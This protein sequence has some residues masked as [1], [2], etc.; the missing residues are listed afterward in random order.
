MM[1]IKYEV[2]LNPVDLPIT[3]VSLFVNIGVKHDSICGI[4]HLIE[5]VIIEELKKREPELF[6]RSFINGYIDKEFTCFYATVLSEDLNKLL[7]LFSCLYICM[8]KKLID[9]IVKTQKKV[10]YNIENQ[11]ILSNFKLINILMLEQL[12]FEGGLRKTIIVDEKFLNLDEW[13]IRNFCNQIYSQVEHYLIVSGNIS[14]ADVEKIYNSGCEIIS[15]SGEIQNITE[16]STILLNKIVNIDEIE[17]IVAISIEN[18]EGINEY[19]ALHIVCLFYKIYI[20]N[21]LKHI[22]VFLRDVTFKLY[23]EKIIILFEYNDKYIETISLINNI[24]IEDYMELYEDVKKHF[25]YAYLQKEC[26]LIEFNKEI[27]KMRRFFGKKLTFINVVNYI[28][29]VDVKLIKKI[30]TKIVRGK[31]NF[32]SEGI[33]REYF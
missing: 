1:K 23:S 25:L 4:T 10:I 20:N 7:N 26:N 22:D 15:T 2:I 16:R 8:E 3:S 13:Q 27:Y 18:L 12:I 21:Q 9:E 28:N 19:Y 24:K 29:G 31:Y 14:E 5:H 17:K 11:R 30:H 6:R 32:L 33:I